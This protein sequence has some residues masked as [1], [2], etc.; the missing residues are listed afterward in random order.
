MRARVALSFRRTLSDAFWRNGDLGAVASHGR[1]GKAWACH[2][3]DRFIYARKQ[4]DTRVECP[5]AYL[6]LASSDVLFPCRRECESALSVAHVWID[7]KARRRF[8]GHLQCHVK[9]KC[10][11]LLYA[12]LYNDTL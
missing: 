9:M 11:C 1:D 4:R 5:K 2:A 7:A 8:H 6:S 10:E 3:E 12:A